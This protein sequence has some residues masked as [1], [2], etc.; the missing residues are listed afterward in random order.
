MARRLIGAT[1]LAL[2]LVVIGAMAARDAA[3]QIVSEPDRDA[4]DPA[5]VVSPSGVATLAWTVYESPCSELRTVQVTA[6]GTVGPVRAFP[7]AN[8]CSRQVDLAVDPE[9]SVTAVWSSSE[10]I[11]MS[12]LKPDGTPEMARAIGMAE[13]IATPEIDVDRR[14]RSVVVYQGPSVPGHRNRSYRA[15]A[16]MVSP[17]GTPSSPIDISRAAVY[18]PEL[19]MNRR[20]RATIVWSTGDYSPKPAYRIQLRTLSRGGSRGRIRTL[21]RPGQRGFGPT[22]DVDRAGVATIAWRSNNVVFATQLDAGGEVRS[23]PQRLTDAGDGTP[24]DPRVA[25]PASGPAIVAWAGRGADG[26][27]GLGFRVL[28]SRLK[29]GR[30]A[31][32]RSLAVDARGPELLAQERG[33]MAAYTAGNGV[34][35]IRR[36]RADGRR[37]PARQ[38]H[39]A[40]LSALQ[41]AADERGRLAL[42]GVVSI[43]DD[44]GFDD[45]SA[46]EFL[47]PG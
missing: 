15:R 30:A 38:V 5:L 42:A 26:S 17:R 46:I 21:T 8:R 34:T 14:G 40:H 29:R 33:V 9:G 18:A 16:V 7:G 27:G 45:G 10:G 44:S 11:Q 13:D 47:Q 43:V 4:V 37:E 12:R 3:A 41:L 24:S 39:D 22:L 1:A 20:G 2:V 36:V 35:S 31:D 25:S 19:A 23:G 28:Y 6:D 32:A